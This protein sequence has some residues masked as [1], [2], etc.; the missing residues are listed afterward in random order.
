MWRLG[1]P[2]DSFLALV[3]L[4]SPLSQH[5]PLWRGDCAGAGGGLG[6]GERLGWG[7]PR[8]RGGHVRAGEA[9]PDWEMQ[10]ER[11]RAGPWWGNW[12]LAG[13]ERSPSWGRPHH[14][15]TVRPWPSGSF[16]PSWTWFKS[17]A[18]PQPFPPPTPFR[19]SPSGP[20]GA[21]PPHLT[22]PLPWPLTERPLCRGW[23]GRWAVANTPR[24][25]PAQWPATASSSPQLSR[26]PLTASS[27]KTPLRTWGHPGIHPYPFHHFLFQKLPGLNLPFRSSFQSPVDHLLLRPQG[28]HCAGSQ[29]WLLHICPQGAPMSPPC[30]GGGEREMGVILEAE[31]QRPIP[32]RPPGFS[33]CFICSELT[34]SQ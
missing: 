31:K 2:G 5:S 28:T 4:I 34:K 24:Y 11:N 27:R 18:T 20:W 3:N 15:L 8:S 7:Q 19:P 21:K 6:G 10:L 12:V 22:G 26:Q 29:S 32:R 9:W 17:Q 1:W 13:S 25:I 33:R 30:V 14:G 23:G 16:C